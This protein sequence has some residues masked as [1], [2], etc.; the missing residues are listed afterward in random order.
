M[1][2][3]TRAIIQVEKGKKYEE[4]INIHFFALRCDAMRCDAD[5]LLGSCAQFHQRQI[6]NRMYEIN[7]YFN[8]MLFRKCRKWSNLSAKSTGPVY[9]FIRYCKCNKHRTHTIAYTI[10]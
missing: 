10:H 8:L 7:T 2:E 9:R 3:R 5:A 6:Q 4:E 1:S